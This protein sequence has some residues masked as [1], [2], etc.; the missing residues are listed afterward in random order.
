MFPNSTNN[1]DPNRPALPTDANHRV[2]LGGVSVDDG[3][4]PVPIEVD[5]NTGGLLVTVSGSNS[6]RETDSYGIGAISETATHKYFFFENKDL[7]W[8]ILRKTLA[9]NVFDFARG[10]GGYESVYVDKDSAPSG[11][12]VF[13]TYGATF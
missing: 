7:D 5:P 8:Y 11:S 1:E 13:D 6:G 12:P 3:K 10:S 9:T 2:L 4:T